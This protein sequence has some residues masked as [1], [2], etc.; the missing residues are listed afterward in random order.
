MY[1][2][3][4]AGAGWGQDSDSLMAGRVLESTEQSLVTQF[5]PKGTLDL[6]AVMSLPTLFASETQRDNSQP[7]ARIGTLT[8]VKPNG[9][10]YQLN[11]TF[12]PDIPPIPNSLLE[13]L[14]DA[15]DIDV[16]SSIDEFHRT[17]WSIKD[18]DLFKVL[19]KH[20]L[21]QREKPKV[22]SLGN[23]SIDQSLVAV[24]MPFD[25]R[26]DPVHAALQGAVGSAGMRLQRVDDIWEHDHIM[27]DVASLLWR[28][29]VVICDL[30]Y[31]NPNV[32]YEMGIAHTIGR[33]VIMLAQNKE[34]VPFDV[35]HMRYVSYYPNAEG[36]LALANEVRKR[37]DTLRGLA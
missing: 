15:L 27:Q 28:A 17:H 6:A 20:N 36:L 10:E 11:Y 4:V 9:R 23:D 31:R 3:L 18:V 1:N 33:D 2:L 19:F 37:L 16:K 7:A 25:A 32:C 34:D 8:R 35:R 14:A 26:F 30:T 22:F 12:D 5:M 24:M 13:A 29:S 21:V